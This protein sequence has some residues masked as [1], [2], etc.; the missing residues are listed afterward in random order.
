MINGSGVKGKTRLD[1]ACSALTAVPLQSQLN[2][3]HSLQFKIMKKLILVLVL[4]FAGSVFG[5][6]ADSWKGVVIDRT[7]PQQAIALLGKPATDKKAPVIDLYVGRILSPSY[8]CST[9]N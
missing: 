1:P 8:K 7:T 3:L 5:Q 6:N 4:A 2:C 9:R